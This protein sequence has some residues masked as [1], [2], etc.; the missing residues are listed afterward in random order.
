MMGPNIS[1]QECC[2]IQAERIPS[3]PSIPSHTLGMKSIPSDPITAD[4]SF[5]RRMFQEERSPC[6]MPCS[7]GC[8]YK[9]RGSGMASHQACTMSH[10]QSSSAQTAVKRGKWCRPWACRGKYVQALKWPPP[11]PWYAHLAPSTPSCPHLGV[12]VLEA[13]GYADGDGEHG[14]H[15]GPALDARALVHKPAAVNG[16][17]GRYTE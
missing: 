17:L 15:L 12:Q 4:M 1:T 2:C 5:V 9:G 8:G 14:A 11:P 13:P 3:A 7:E 16:I 10:H 6:T